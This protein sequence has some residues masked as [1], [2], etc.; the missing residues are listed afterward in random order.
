MKIENLI[1]SIGEAVQDAHKMIEQKYVSNFFDHYF[2]GKVDEITNKYTYKPKTVEILFEN[3]QDS[4]VVS[5]PIAALVQHTNMNLDYVK[6][7]LNINVINESEEEIEITPQ[8][9]GGKSDADSR[10]CGEMELLFKCQDAPEG[11][12]RIETCLNSIL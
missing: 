1:A 2:Q 5:A 4:K 9:A 8:D 11:I 12:A 3:S 6:L 10:K 7:N